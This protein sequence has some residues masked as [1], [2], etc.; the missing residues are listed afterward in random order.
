MIHG[1]SNIIHEFFGTG[2]VMMLNE[3]TETLT[4]FCESIEYPQLEQFMA[5]G[6]TA[7]T[8]AKAEDPSRL[9]CFPHTHRAINKRMPKRYAKDLNTDIKQIQLSQDREEFIELGGGR[10][11]SGIFKLC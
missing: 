7:I 1:T 6:S 2:L 5:D 8:T 11:L 9:M 4:Q 10:K 3:D